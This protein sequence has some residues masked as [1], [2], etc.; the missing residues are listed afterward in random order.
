MRQPA[1][2]AAGRQIGVLRVDGGHPVQL[3]DDVG[4]RRV[5]TFDH[6]VHRLGQGCTLVA[7]APAGD[8]SHRPGGPRPT[9]PLDTSDRDFVDVFG[10]LDDDTMPQNVTRL[11]DPRRPES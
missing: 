6:G 3:V 9:I 7:V 2:E 8:R 5:G 11:R 4:Q 1:G 10:S